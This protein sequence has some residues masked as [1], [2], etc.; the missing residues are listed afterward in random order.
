MDDLCTLLL[1]THRGHEPSAR[2]LWEA[3]A[4]RLVAVARAVLGRRCGANDAEDAVQAVFCRVLELDRRSVR[5][6]RDPGAWL[7]QMTRRESLNMLRAARRAAV[8][9]REHDGGRAIGASQREAGLTAALAALPRHLREVVVLRHTAGL[10]FEQVSLTL[11]VNRNTVASRH[12]LAME[13]LR[14]ALGADGDGSNTG[15]RSEPCTT[16]SNGG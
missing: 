15:R 10:T 6:V 3:Q 14:N 9:E 12:R 2:R 16:I 4:P 13:R 5:A 8:R 11:G 7:A 1:R